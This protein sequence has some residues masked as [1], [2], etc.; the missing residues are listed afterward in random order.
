MNKNCQPRRRTQNQLYR[1]LPRTNFVR[2][3][4][5]I[6]L[7]MQLPGWKQDEIELSVEEH[8]LSVTGKATQEQDGYTVK[9]QGF[10][11]TDFTR[12]FRLGSEL[13]VDAIEATMNQGILSIRIPVQEKA[14]HS[15]EIK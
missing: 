13:N 12:R 5:S 2:T 4:D 8:I 14:K 11:R 9:R 15:I 7:D 3:E 6:R 1:T 10:R